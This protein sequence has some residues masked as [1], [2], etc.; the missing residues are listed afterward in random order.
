F[1]TSEFEDNLRRALM[2]DKLRAAVAGW[3]T[4]TDA[5]V[6]DESRLRNEKARLEVVAIT[7]DAFRDKVTATDEE[8]AAHFE[9][10]KESYRIGERRAVKYVV[11]DVESV[12]DSVTVHD[13][14]VEALYKQNIAQYT[15]PRQVRAF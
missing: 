4:V 3:I 15:T 8:L 1:T 5:E 11:V 12:R 7:P 14:D 10:N 2:I 9:A 6:D 13:A